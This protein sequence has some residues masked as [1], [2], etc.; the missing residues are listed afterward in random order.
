MKRWEVITC[1]ADEDD[2]VFERTTFTRRKA[3]YYALR[4]NKMW[5]NAGLPLYTTVRPCEAWHRLGTIL[6]LIGM[7]ALVLS[8]W[9]PLWIL[10]V[11]LGIV[12]IYQ[13]GKDIRN[14]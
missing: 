10:C 2:V 8:P 13:M 6:A 1:K 3:D 5:L 11:V 7:Y 4:A 14:G 9:W 12:W